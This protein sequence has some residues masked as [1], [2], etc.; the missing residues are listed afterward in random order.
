MDSSKEPNAFLN[1]LKIHNILSK[2]NIS[3]PKIYEIEIEKKIIIT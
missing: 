2:I 3:I 1:F